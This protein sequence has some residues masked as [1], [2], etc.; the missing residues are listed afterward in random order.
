MQI[1]HAAKEAV[2]AEMEKR[3]VQLK[4]KISSPRP[5]DN[6]EKDN[7]ATWWY[8]GQIAA[9]NEMVKTLKDD[10]NEQ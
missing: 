4:D 6:T 3:I 1:D 9:L 7:V 8:R 5:Q 2:L 10:D